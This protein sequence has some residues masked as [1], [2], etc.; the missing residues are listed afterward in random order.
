MNILLINHY[1]GGPIYG[2]EYR[3][4]YLSREWVKMGH[5]VT[6]LGASYS[7]LRQVQPNATTDFQEESVNGIKY[8]WLVTPK[9]KGAISRIIN[10]IIF[11]IKLFINYRKI[12][13]RYSPNIVIAS[14]TYP[15]D[16]IPANKIAKLSNAKYIYEIHD[17]W[18]LSPMLI[19]GY[20]KYHPFILIMQYGENY[21]Y[22][23]C[24]KVVSLLWNAEKHCI[25]H[26]L[27]TKKFVCVPNGYNPE[28]WQLESINKKLP[29]EHSVTF[30][31]LHN[32]FIVGFAGGFAVS[33]AL[34]T[35]V[36]TAK[37]MQEYT[38]I[39]FVLVGDGQEKENIK[40]LIIKYNLKNITL[41]PSVSKFLIPALNSHFHVSYMGG[42]HSQLHQYGTSYNKMTDYMLSAKPIIYAIDEPGCIVEK[43]GCGIQVQAESPKLNVDAILRIKSLSIIDREKMGLKGRTYAQKYL[44]WQALSLKFLKAI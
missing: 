31:K 12:A 14:S 11:F 26:G 20:S 42:I 16:N 21:A 9:Y 18:P 19:G 3:P 2:M 17:I 28:D 1:A 5:N 15:L 27:N 38:D 32:K 41:L 8:V 25:Q 39:H 40:T 35:L 43:I 29:Y 13:K 24:D 30:E 33:G 44:Q 10:I 6:I 22:K 4:Y 36:E 7:H 23:H 37:E 34:T